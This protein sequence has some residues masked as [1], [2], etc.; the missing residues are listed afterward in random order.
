MLFG[1]RAQLLEAVA[2][3]SDAKDL[4]VLSRRYASP[5]T[6]HVRRRSAFALARNDDD[7]RLAVDRAL[8]EVYADPQFGELYSATFGAPD[9]GTVAFFR[10][11]AVPK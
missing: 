8:T 7:F 10:A 1:D 6:F 4:R 2:A 5:V 9:A 11:A 3:Q